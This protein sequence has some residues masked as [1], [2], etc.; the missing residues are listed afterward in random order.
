MSEEFR[1]LEK[2]VEQSKAVDGKKGLF[3]GKK[4]KKKKEDKPINPIVHE[5]YS[6]IITL[7]AAFIIAMVIRMFVFEPIKVDGRSM[8]NTLQDKEIVYVSKLDYLFGDVQRN[9]VVICRYPNRTGASFNLGAGLSLDNYTLFVKR[10]VALPGDTVKIADGK[11]YINGEMQE[12]PPEMGSVPYDFSEI[13]LGADQYFV[14]GDNRRNSHD[15]RSSDVG[16]LSRSMIMGKARFVLWPLN[17]IRG[18][19]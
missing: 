15:S 10:V 3:G 11:L 17:R 2:S 9:D 13:T 5:I 1:E 16:P 8:T 7:L 4:G 12:D 14:I 19:K 18:V 6:W